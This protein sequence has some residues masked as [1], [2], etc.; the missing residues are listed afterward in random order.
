MYISCIIPTVGRESLKQTVSSLI[1]QPFRELLVMWDSD[2]EG[3]YKTR[4]R[5]IRQS[6][7]DVIAFTDDDCVVSPDWLERAKRYFEEGYDM[8]SGSTVGRLLTDAR[9]MGSTCNLFVRS[10]VFGKVGLFDDGFKCLGDLDFF[11]RVKRAGFKIGY[12]EDVRVWHPLEPGL[13]NSR[14]AES[15]KRLEIKHPEEFKRWQEQDIVWEG[16]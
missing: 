15:M 5:G 9:V 6:G 10:S 14:D 7:G 11:W 1:G 8:I 16:A 12:A 4:N 2:R 3:V 13:T